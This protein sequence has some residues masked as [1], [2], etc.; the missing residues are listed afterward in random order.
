MNS[1]IMLIYTDKSMA[2]I[3]YEDVHD[4]SYELQDGR[5]YENAVVYSQGTIKKA[6]IIEHEEFIEIE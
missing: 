1:K 3:T 6:K 2:K 4:Y 5:I